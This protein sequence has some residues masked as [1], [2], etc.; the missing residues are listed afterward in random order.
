[1][2]RPIAKSEE[3]WSIGLA[4]YITSASSAGTVKNENLVPRDYNRAG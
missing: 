3:G 2:R 4:K 1:M